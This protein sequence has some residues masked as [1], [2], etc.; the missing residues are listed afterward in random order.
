MTRSLS[1]VI[2]NLALLGVLVC[3]Q[4]PTSAA[5][6][7]NA[8][9]NGPDADVKQ[10]RLD[11]LET[12]LRTMQPGP[13]RDY[14]SGVLANRAGHVEESIGLL[15]SA[16]PGTRTSR[17]DRAEIAL[18]S[19]ADDYIKRFDYTNAAQAY[20]DLLAHFASQLDRARLQETQDDAG[21]MHILQGAPAQTITWDGPVRLTTERDVVGL[22]NTE[23]TVNG[24]RQQWLLDTGANLSVVSRSFAQRLG[25]QFLPGTAQAMSGFTG[26][27]NPLQVAL[28]PT[29]PIG[30]AT[31][32]NVVVIVFDDANLNLDAGKQKYQIQAIIGYPVFQALGKITFL[33]SGGFEA[34]DTTQ[35]HGTGARMYMELLNPVIECGIEG[36]N[37][38]FSFDT[39]ADKTLLSVR[40]YD[41]FRSESGRWK[42][43]KSVLVGAGG[44]VK[45]T[46]YRQPQLNL[47]IGDKT[48][49][50]KQLEVLGST[51]GTDLDNVYGN[52]GQDVVAKFASFTLD[53]STMT[54]SLGDPL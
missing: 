47:N 24:V 32:H 42:K 20:D 46:V 1:A 51:L 4:T 9:S 41:R 34:G 18:E 37:L 5:S 25:L 35:S 30:G 54:F 10:F 40:Y 52:L 15:K 21:V 53:F 3:A 7:K 12:S 49:T 8:V 50:L 28:L 16:L 6:G 14:F 39:G 43:A 29:L 11:E 22:L 45:Q 44:A 19:L 48:V 13:E 31:L 17:P 38:P 33:H 27:E 36:K 26:I 2:G 23:L